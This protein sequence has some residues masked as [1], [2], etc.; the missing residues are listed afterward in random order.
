MLHLK[1]RK[2]NKQ[3]EIHRYIVVVLVAVVS[4]LLNFVILAAVFSECVGCP[5][6]HRHDLFD[7]KQ[8]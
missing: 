6:G 8:G 1:T 3:Y 2:I 7:L 5:A 4:E